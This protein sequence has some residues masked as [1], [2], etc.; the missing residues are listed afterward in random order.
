MARA[1]YQRS[2]VYIFDDPLSAVDSHVCRHLFENV[3][4]PGGLLSEKVCRSRHPESLLGLRVLNAEL[5]G[6]TV[7]CMFLCE[8]DSVALFFMCK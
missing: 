5:E 3:I 4:G 6:G 8:L 2:D 1:V 7:E